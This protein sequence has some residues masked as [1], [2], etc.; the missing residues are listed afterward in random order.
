ME[1]I[2]NNPY[3]APQSDVSIANPN[4]GAKNFK[5][6]SAWGVF[7]LTII[8]FGIYSIYW[9]YTRTT[10]LNSFHENKISTPLL[11]MFLV[12]TIAS[13]VSGFLDPNDQTQALISGLISIVYLVFYL[14]IIF[15]LHS[16]LAEICGEKFNAILTFF[17]GAIYLQY[18]INKSI[19]QN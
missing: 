19:D 2:E 10:T 11:N 12:A 17:G 7:G 14:I 13:F 9:I 3:N 5:R 1:H 15:S 4:N 8:T 6:F 18:K 16:R